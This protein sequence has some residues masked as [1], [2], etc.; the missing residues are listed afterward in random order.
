MEHKVY[1]SGTRI[2]FLNLLILLGFLLEGCTIE[3]QKKVPEGYQLG[4][5]TFHRVCAQCHG[6]D[7][8]GGKRAPTFLQKKFLKNNYSNARIHRTILNG[9]DS[10]AMPS[11]KKGSTLRR[12]KK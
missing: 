3:P 11:Q 2:F 6:A 5:I 7:T 9:S 8:R 12:L 1:R 10:G 4:Q